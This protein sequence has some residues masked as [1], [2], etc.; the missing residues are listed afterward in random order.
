MCSNY[1]PRY[2]LTAFRTHS[3]A[4]RAAVQLGVPPKVAVA[5][6]PAVAEHPQASWFKQHARQKRTFEALSAA[7]ARCEC[8]CGPQLDESTSPKQT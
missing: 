3:A 5:D 2:A 1:G 6:A 7:F 8:A 4:D